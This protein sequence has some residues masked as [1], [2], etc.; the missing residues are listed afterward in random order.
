MYETTR[1]RIRGK[2]STEGVEWDW[3]RKDV[4]IYSPMWPG[5][6][7]GAENSEGDKLE[8]RY[9]HEGLLDSAT[10]AEGA[11]KPQKAALGQTA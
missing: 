5:S 1:G 4:S 9:T 7:L 8:V 6:G 10:Y 2:Y 11:A 3:N